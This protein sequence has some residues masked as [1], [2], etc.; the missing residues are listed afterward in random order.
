M[1]REWNAMCEPLAHTREEGCSVKGGMAEKLVAFL[2]QSISLVD[3][4]T[5]RTHEGVTRCSADPT[6][7]SAMEI[8]VQSNGHTR[9]ASEG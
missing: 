1:R 9:G 2:S 7:V 4:P 5:G 8:R 3:T 6:E